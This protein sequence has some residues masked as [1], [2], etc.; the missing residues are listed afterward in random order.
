M[1]TTTTTTDPSSDLV[2]GA[3]VGLVYSDLDQHRRLIHLVG[4]DPRVQGVELSVSAPL[5]KG[6]PTIVAALKAADGLRD[7]IDAYF[8]HGLVDDVTRVAFARAFSNSYL[9]KHP[10]S[11]RQDL[12][13]A[14]GDVFVFAFDLVQ[15]MQLPV[16]RV[17]YDAIANGPHDAAMLARVRAG[18][19]VPKDHLRVV[20]RLFLDHP[21]NPR[22][23]LDNDVRAAAERLD[24]PRPFVIEATTS[25]AL[26]GYAKLVLGDL[27][28]AVGGAAAWLS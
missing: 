5:F 16:P 25:L 27:A 8:D 14:S 24:I 7:K 6:S 19:G 20:L 13:R 12:F 15:P 10:R 1:T 9:A 22:R 28:T 26:P 21:L 2:I 17:V 18:D 23:H 4:D 3:T 11:E